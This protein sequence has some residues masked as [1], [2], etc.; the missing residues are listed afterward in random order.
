MGT[1]DRPA[2]LDEALAVLQKAPRL[3]VAGGTDIYPARVGRPVDDDVLDV[4]GIAGLRGIAEDTDGH[5][6]GALTTWSALAEAPLPRWFDGYRQAARQVGGAQIQNAGTLAGNL[7]NASPAADGTPCLLALDAAVELASAGG[8]LRAVPVE[9]FV[10]G[11]R[12]TVRRA[13]EL[14]TAIR[15]PRCAPGSRSVF[16]KLG[17]RAYLVISI[18]MVSAV[19]EP[20]AGGRVGRLRVAVGACS[21]VARRLR[22]LEADLAGAPIGPGLA[23]LVRPEHLAGLTPIDDVRGT[24]EYRRHAA[25]ALVRRALIQLAGEEG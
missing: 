1:Y 6:L 19:L 3:V 16:L 7:C 2:G 9:A 24:A 21:A 12:R 10:T 23:R 17:A 14:V 22:G 20:A 11:S 13:D 4:T 5:R 8:G 18:V 15:V 25:L